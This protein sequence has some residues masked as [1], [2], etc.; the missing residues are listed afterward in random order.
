M[1]YHNLVNISQIPCL[2]FLIKKQVGVL[3]GDIIFIRTRP[4][5]N[6]QIPAEAL[7]RLLFPHI[8]IFISHLLWIQ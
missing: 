4:I 2:A 5:A 7:N 6:F 3:G 1:Q 8:I